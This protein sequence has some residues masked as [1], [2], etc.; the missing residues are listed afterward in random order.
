M[1]KAAKSAASLCQ[2]H[3]VIAV[4]C[5]LAQKPQWGRKQ[6]ALKPLNVSFICFYRRAMA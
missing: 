6:G 2:D 1:E 4:G 5:Q 3:S